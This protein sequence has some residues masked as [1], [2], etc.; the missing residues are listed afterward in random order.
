[1]PIVTPAAVPGRVGL[2]EGDRAGLVGRHVRVGGRGVRTRAGDGLPGRPG[3]GRGQRLRLRQ[4]DG[5]VQVDRRDAGQL[6]GLQHAAGGHLGAYVADAV[7]LLVDL[8]AELAQLVGDVLRLPLVGG[9]DEDDVLGALGLRL[10]Q[11]VEVV[12]PQR[13]GGSSLRDVLV[14]RCRRAG[15]GDTAG[16]RHGADRLSIPPQPITGANQIIAVALSD[17]FQ[18]FPAKKFS[19]MSPSTPLIMAFAKQ[20]VKLKSRKKDQKSEATET[21]T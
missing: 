10:G 3:V 12:R 8:A 21:E 7:H 16:Q 11:Q 20:G 19:G 1:M 5:L 9:D 2:L 13:V 18:V 17:R 4:R 15:R 14:G 6:G